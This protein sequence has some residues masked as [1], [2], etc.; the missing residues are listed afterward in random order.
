MNTIWSTLGLAVL[1][2]AVLLGTAA[3]EES[4][5]VEVSGA[6][7]AASFVIN[8]QPSSTT[9]MT[10]TRG[11]T[12]SATDS[13]TISANADWKLDVDDTSETPASPG[14]MVGT[15]LG[16]IGSPL[17]NPFKV[18][19]TGSAQTGLATGPV[20]IVSNGAAGANNQAVTIDYEQPVSG[21]EVAGSYSIALTYT[22]SARVT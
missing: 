22:L 7:A 15:S 6:V 3:A 4:N 20:S 8:V 2:I 13:I 10:L 14:Y 17:E 5:E 12:A 1:G 11:T 18:G 21:D 19:P 9:T 16:I